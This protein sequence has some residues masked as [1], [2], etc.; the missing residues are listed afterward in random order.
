M[1][2][3]IDHDTFKNKCAS[4]GLLMS[5]LFNKNCFK[6]EAFLLLGEEVTDDIIGDSGFG[7]KGMALELIEEKLST[8]FVDPKRIAEIQVIQCEKFD[9]SRLLVLCDEINVAYRSECVLSVGMLLR[10][11][12]DYVPPI[13]GFASFNELAHNYKDGGR[14][15]GKLFKNLQNSFR[16]TADGYLHTQARKKDSIPLMK[17]VDYQSELD[18]LL[19]EVVRILK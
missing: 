16:N 8:D 14:S 9:L 19:S 17:Q 2:L 6:P 4:K 3:E 11:I 10:A 5:G 15:H 18:I 13:F 12:M 7:E 1:K